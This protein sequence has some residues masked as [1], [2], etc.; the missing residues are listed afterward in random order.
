MELGCTYGID[1][2]LKTYSLTANIKNDNRLRWF[3]YQINRNSLFTNYRVNKF[4]NYISPLCSFCSHLV[5]AP[6]S[7]ELISHIFFEC[8]FVLQLWQQV[9][10]WLGGFNIGLELDRTK[11][12][13]GIHSENSQS[14]KNFVILTVKYYIWRS[15]F[16]NTAL[17]LNGYQDFLK[18][19][20]DDHKNA[21]FYQGKDIYFEPWIVI[22][23]CLE[24][25]CIGISLAP[26]PDTA[27]PQAQAQPPPCPP[28]SPT[29]PLTRPTGQDPTADNSMTPI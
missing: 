13:F 4:K 1:F 24:R 29:D 20:L 26:L 3:Q 2:W 16:Q 19:K 10:G 18:N 6:Q 23:T 17:T 25:I 7:N 27:D 14:I 9:R 11:L 5:D 8:D 22:Y 12:L 28:G 21:C 15:K